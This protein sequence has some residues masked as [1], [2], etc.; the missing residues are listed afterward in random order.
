MNIKQQLLKNTSLDWKYTPQQDD[1]L[2][3]KLSN[4]PFD[5]NHFQIIDYIFFSSFT[6]YI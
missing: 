5:R 3:S 4:H 1:I 2:M 6:Q